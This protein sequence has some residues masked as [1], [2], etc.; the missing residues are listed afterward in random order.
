MIAIAYYLLKV[1]ICS[2][3]L[4]GYYHIAL[5]NKAFNAW[6]RFY[7]LACIPFSILLPLVEI[8]WTAPANEGSKVIQAM[9]IVTGADEY[10]K[11]SSGGNLASYLA[12]LPV[13]GY[14][15]VSLILAV[16]FTKAVLRIRKILRKYEAMPL[17]HFYFL[18]TGEPGT[19][20]SFFRY[21][22]WNKEISLNDENGQKILEHELVHMEQR[23][24]WDKIFIHA[25]LL[26]F[27][28]NPFFWLMRHELAMIHEFIADRKAVGNGDVQAF[29]QLI[30]ASAF[31]A[32]QGLLTN[33]F[34]QS[35]IKRRLAMITKQTH[36]MVAYVT[37]LLMLPLIAFTFFVFAIKHPGSTEG[38][39]TVKLPK[40]YTIVVDAGHGGD[41]DGVAQGDAKEKDLALSI[42]KLVRDLNKN[43]NINIVLS[44]ESDVKQD[45]KEKVSF[46]SNKKADLFISMHINGSENSDLSGLEA[47]IASEENAHIE[48]SA[49]MAHILVNN[50]QDVYPGERAVKQRTSKIWV[51]DQNICPAVI[52]ECGYLTNPGD[53]AFVSSTANQEKIARQV[54]RSIEDYF[55]PNTKFVTGHPLDQAQTTGQPLPGGQPLGQAQMVGQPLS[56]GQPLGQAQMV[57]EPLAIGYSIADTLPKK[58]LENVTFVYSDG[59]RETLTPAEYQKRNGRKD[60]S[61]TADTIYVNG[62]RLA[63][64]RTG[65]SQTLDP[66]YYLDGKLISKK[67]MDAISP[68]QISSV[69]VNKP[70]DGS[71]GTVSIVTKKN[72]KQSG[73]TP[74][75]KFHGM[76]V[77]DISKDSMTVLINGN[78][79]ETF[80]GEALKVSPLYI[81]DGQEMDEVAVNAIE[82][83]KIQEINVLKGKSAEKIYGEKGKN[84]VVVIKLKK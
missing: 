75:V 71:Q 61:I 2:G 30:L 77:T 36:P 68:E 28:I 31:P 9:Q 74:D 23:H 42:A 56:G 67:E 52:L 49:L 41:D 69:S 5:R 78:K 17:G 29:A 4:Y 22:V 63:P 72:A 14:A 20:F 38:N 66:L 44:R 55:N 37:R 45:V 18:N 35:P 65:V 48:R 59:T 3:L 83:E 34:F 26:A 25:V 13:A 27:W 16:I 21:L 84:G 50:L 82:P 46:A 39:E 1:V 15:L 43:P 73:S 80:K 8:Y 12:W 53:K 64:A 10:V 19:P 24:S 11:E 40:T 81:V 70:K 60:I 57:G 51:L 6:N 62:H 76:V 7:L 79:V 32:H 54:L 33:S 47:Y 58:K